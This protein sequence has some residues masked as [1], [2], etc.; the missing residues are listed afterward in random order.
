[1]IVMTRA[2][3]EACERNSSA[4]DLASARKALAGNLCRCTGYGKILASALAAA[5]KR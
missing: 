4:A 1:M 3:L 2:W 5:A